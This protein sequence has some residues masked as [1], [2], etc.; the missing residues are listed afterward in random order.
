MS[1]LNKYITLLE[2]LTNKKV[3]LVEEENSDNILIPRRS[4]EEREKN[5]LIAT[6]KKIQEYIK[7]GSKGDLDLT[8]C[9]NL[10]GLNNLRYV[11][12][13]LYLSDTSI[14]KLP[15]DLVVEETIY[16]HN[17]PLSK[18]EKLFNQYRRKFD[19]II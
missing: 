7:N 4:P 13:C 8:G 9:I 17:T 1:N 2:K 6:N 11:E 14:E 19:I 18:N 12:G 3:R 15:D 5:F 10:K 16:L